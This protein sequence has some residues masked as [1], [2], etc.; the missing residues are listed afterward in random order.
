MPNITTF[1]TFNNQ[2]EEA[3]RFYT[4]IFPNSHI[5][6]ISHY[7]DLGPKFDFSAGTVMTIC[8]IEFDWPVNK[9]F[10]ITSE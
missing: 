3:A 4:S 6:K 2:A 7:P 5:T 10:V 8:W 1:L 9:S